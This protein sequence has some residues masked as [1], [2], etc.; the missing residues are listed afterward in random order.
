MIRPTNAE[1][2]ILGV[3]WQRGR[4]FHGCRP[5][6]PGAYEPAGK[7]LDLVIGGRC[8]LADRFCD[9]VHDATGLHPEGLADLLGVEVFEHDGYHDVHDRADRLVRY[10]LDTA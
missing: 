9:L 2:A 8:P 5:P 4:W 3:L 1:L 7:P 6:S 10:P